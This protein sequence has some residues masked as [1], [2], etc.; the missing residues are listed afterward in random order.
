MGCRCFYH[1]ICYDIFVY[2]VYFNEEVPSQFAEKKILCFDKKE[3]CDTE[4]LLSFV[5]KVVCN[6]L[7]QWKH[8]GQ[9]RDKIFSTR[10]LYVST[11]NSWELNRSSCT[12]SE[13]CRLCHSI[14]H[15]KMIHQKLKAQETGTSF[16]LSAE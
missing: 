13:S 3:N 4:K 1:K 7:R 9:Q 8:R 5:C 10:K 16:P 2:C 6:V 14:N 12:W 15:W 11:W